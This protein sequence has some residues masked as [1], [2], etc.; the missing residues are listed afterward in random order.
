MDARSEADF[1]S[2]KVNNVKQKQLIRIIK[3]S[4]KGSIHYSEG[5]ATWK[6]ATNYF[7]PH[8]GGSICPSNL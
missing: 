4:E 1:I 5:D 7:R 2:E 8:D 6:V 3:K